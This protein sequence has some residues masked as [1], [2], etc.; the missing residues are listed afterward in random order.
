MISFEF[1]GRIEDRNAYLAIKYLPDKLRAKVAVHAN[2]TTLRKV[3]AVPLTIKFLSFCVQVDLFG[4]IPPGL[5][6][7]LVLK[8]QSL[9]LTPGDIVCRYG[10]VG[11]E[12]YIVSNGKVAVTT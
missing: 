1:R 5:L 10:D 11:R 3:R 12:M 2:L 8:M 7:E 9:L 4:D 6:H